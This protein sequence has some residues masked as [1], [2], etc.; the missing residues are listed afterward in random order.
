[1]FGLIKEDRA[2]QWRRPLSWWNLAALAPVLLLLV[3]SVRTW[4]N[5]AQI[6]KRQQTAVGIIDGHDPPNHDRYHYSFSVNERRFSGWAYPSDRRDFHV[7][8]QIAVYYDPTRPSENSA[9]DF[10][11]VNPGGVVFVGSL[12]LACVLVP[13][14]IYFQR[15]SRRRSAA[16]GAVT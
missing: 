12:S 5:S 11:E 10:G 15:R 9:Y 4:W 2:R 1:M 6:A 13:T 14:Y 3:V 7:G 16:T 8:Q